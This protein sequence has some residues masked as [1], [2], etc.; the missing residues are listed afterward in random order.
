MAFR[1]LTQS[2]TTAMLHIARDYHAG[3]IRLPTEIEAINREIEEKT[4]QAELFFSR[5]GQVDMALVNEVT[6]LRLQKDALYGQWASSEAR[7][8]I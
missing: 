4:R 7:D 3:R 2:E 1:T 8:L 6:E 5:L